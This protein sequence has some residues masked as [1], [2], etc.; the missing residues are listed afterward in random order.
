MVSVLEKLNKLMK[1][2]VTDGS[3]IPFIAVPSTA[4]VI[5]IMLLLSPFWRLFTLDDNDVM[6]ECFTITECLTYPLNDGGGP[7]NIWLS[8]IVIFT[9]VV[10]FGWLISY[11]SDKATYS[12]EFSQQTMMGVPFM[13]L[14]SV[15]GIILIAFFLDSFSPSFGTFEITRLMILKGVGICTSLLTIVIVF[16]ALSTNESII[17][18]AAD[19]WLMLMVLGAIST[20]IVYLVIF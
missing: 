16:L 8:F 13:M 9:S 5:Y 18:A 4:I 14:A 3:D 6:K 10:G 19:A 12:E 1:K 20:I 11:P 2:H 15:S 17:E 7:F